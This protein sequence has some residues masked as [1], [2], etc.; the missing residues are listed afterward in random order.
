MVYQLEHLLAQPSAHD[1]YVG[2]ICLPWKVKDQEIRKIQA[3][4]RQG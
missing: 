4:A 3:G 1:Q 2:I